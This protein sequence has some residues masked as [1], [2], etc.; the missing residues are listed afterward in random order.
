MIIKFINF[1]YNIGFKITDI[2]VF[3][4]EYLKYLIKNSNITVETWLKQTRFSDGAK[5]SYSY[6]L[7][8]DM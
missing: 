6:F 7:Y 2:F 8:F 3:I 1:F 4:S 5:R